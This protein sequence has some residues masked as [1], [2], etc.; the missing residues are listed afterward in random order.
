M[1]RSLA[2]AIVAL[3]ACGISPVATSQTVNGEDIRTASN[4][5][6]Q[7]VAAEFDCTLTVLGEPQFDGSSDQWLVPYSASGNDCDDA[8]EQLHARGANAAIGFFQRPTLGQLRM[9]LNEMTR[10]VGSSFACRI[11]LGREPR[12]DVSGHWTAEVLASG[13]DCDAAVTELS[14]AGREY[15]ILFVRKSA[16]GL[17]HDIL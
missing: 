14:R 13:P 15:E 5:I 6:V 16:P 4:E 12:M 17:I 7:A 11:T 2:G 3:G 1:Y 8:S 9:L 10:S